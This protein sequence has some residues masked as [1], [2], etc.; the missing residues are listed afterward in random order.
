M[1][2]IRDAVIHVNQFFR[3]ANKPD[4]AAVEEHLLLDDL[5]DQI[6]R[7]RYIQKKPV[8]YIA[9]TLGYSPTKIKRELKIIREKIEPLLPERNK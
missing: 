1:I 9:D 4:V 7:M 6:Y 5:Q 8:G 3:Y 2:R